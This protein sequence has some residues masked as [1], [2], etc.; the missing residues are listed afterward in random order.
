MANPV[1][2]VLSHDASQERQPTAVPELP[3]DQPYKPS[4]QNY[5]ED[6]IEE[7]EKMKEGV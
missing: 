7:I 3:N 5:A 6:H 1:D 4:K 2:S